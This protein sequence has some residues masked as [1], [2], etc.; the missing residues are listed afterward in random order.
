MNT[1]R[2]IIAARGKVIWSIGP[3]ESVYTALE[4]M[5]EKE[6]GALVVIEGDQLAGM[7]SERDYA[8]KIILKGKSSHET[9]VRE[10]M[11]VEVVTIH[12]DQ[13][14]RDCMKLMSQHHIRHLPVVENAKV[15][16]VISIS[17]VVDQIINQQDETIRFLQDLTL[18]Q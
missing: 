4:K 9:Q 16:G 12:P 10:I 7:F 3:N 18:D 2:Q 6:V 14:L 17:D 15:V 13:N 5:A 1:V 8:R 11:T